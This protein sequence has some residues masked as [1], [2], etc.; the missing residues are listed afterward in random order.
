MNNQPEKKATILVVDDNEVSRDLLY[1]YL[2]GSYNVILASNGLD[3]M[4][5]IEERRQELSLVLLDLMMP[6]LNGFE[7]LEEMNENGWIATLPVVVVSSEWSE[8]FR[9]RAYLYNVYDFI[10]KPIMHDEI[11]A[12][13][14]RIIS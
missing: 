10:S 5:I 6:N 9:N 11:M 8:E 1:E 12:C 14:K 4:D 3:A 7:M 13:V 2:S